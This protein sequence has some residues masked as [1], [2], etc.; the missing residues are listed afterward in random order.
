MA[1]FGLL[2]RLALQGAL[3]VAA[4]Y[5]VCPWAHSHYPHGYVGPIPREEIGRLQG[6]ALRPNERV[7]MHPFLTTYG[8]DRVRFELD[9]ARE[10][11][12]LIE[13]DYWSTS[14]SAK[15]ARERVEMLERRLRTEIIPTTPGPHGGGGQMM[16]A[17]E[18]PISP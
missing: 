10:E 12:K 6:V 2:H 4:A 18:S 15:V 13:A 9:E 5:A 14:E 17:D 11:L 7:L 3:T 1:G 16:L 8:S